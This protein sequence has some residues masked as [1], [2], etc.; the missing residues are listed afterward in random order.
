MKSQQQNYSVGSQTRDQHLARKARETV[1]KHPG[2]YTKRSTD[3]HCKNCPYH[4]DYPVLAESFPEIMLKNHV[5]F[6]P[7]IR[8]QGTDTG[9]RKDAGN[10]NL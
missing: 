2:Q 10:S 5:G 9:T 8:Q 4:L 7:E 1:R 3:Y 6:S